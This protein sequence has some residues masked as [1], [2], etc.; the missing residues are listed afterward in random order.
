[1]ASAKIKAFYRIRSYLTQNQ[2]DILFNAYIMSYFNYCPLVWMF[3]SKQAH[4][5]INKTHRRAMCAK[6]NIFSCDYDELLK[7]A[8]SETIHSKNLKWLI[9]E[10]F[11][12][13]NC[14][15]PQ[16]MWDT[17]PLRATHYNSRQGSCI[18]I[19]PA[20]T[21]QSVNFFDFRSA[22][23]WNHLPHFIKSETDLHKFVTSLENVDIYCQCRECSK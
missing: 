10:I 3:C 20:N 19:P 11:K 18:I 4:N 15:N 12:S 22:L 7:L 21:T 9:I 2:A 8:K 13:L 17:F 16:I 23:A 14:L 6:L 5:L 1:M